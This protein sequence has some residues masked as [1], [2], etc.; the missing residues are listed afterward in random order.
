ACSHLRALLVALDLL[1]LPADLVDR[2][3]HV[4]HTVAHACK[5]LELR[6]LLFHCGGQARVGNDGKALRQGRLARGQPY[7]ILTRPAPRRS[8]S[9]SFLFSGPSFFLPSSSATGRA[10]RRFQTKRLA[11]A[12]TGRCGV[13]SVLLV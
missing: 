11:P 7:L 8:D 10:A 13:S 5:Q 12:P 1:A 6:A 4:V 3:V 9:S 2:A